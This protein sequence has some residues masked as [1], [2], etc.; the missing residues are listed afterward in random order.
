VFDPSLGK[1]EGQGQRSK[2]KGRGHQGQKSAFFGSF[3]SLRAVYV[4]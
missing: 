1:L 2:V 3:G 4:W